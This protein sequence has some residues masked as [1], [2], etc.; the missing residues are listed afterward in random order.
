MTE[1][2]SRHRRSVAR[3]LAWVMAGVGVWSLVAWA[4]SRALIVESDARCDADVIVVLAGADSYRAR[5]AHAAELYAQ[6]C[7]SFVVLTNDGVR[8]GWSQTEQRNLMFIERAYRELRRAGIAPERIVVL[9]D[10][11]SGTYDEAIHVRDEA[12]RRAWRRVMIVT[13]PYH[14]RR[15]WW[16][17][18]QAFDGSETKISCRAAR[19][20][21]NA[22][23]VWWLDAK[24]WRD[25][26]GEYAKFGYYLLT[27]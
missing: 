26:A 17:F 1:V 22:P 8:G 12:E 16:S 23:A 5:T 20:D 6:G 14:M 13:S 15:A 3:R 4:A 19:F 7:A 21:E 25:V 11:M 18:R 27:Y 10:I 24:G 9:P 2:R